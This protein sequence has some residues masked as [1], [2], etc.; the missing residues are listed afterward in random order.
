MRRARTVDEYVAMMKD[1]LYE[2]GDMRAAI[3]YDEE[4]MGASIGYIDDIESCLKGIFKEMKSGDYC[5]NTG[6]LPY[7]RVIRDLDDAAIPFRS[8]LIR[9]NDTHK[10]GLEESPDA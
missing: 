8:L 1:A 2:I 6:D 3:E 10:N 5:W 9:I 4:G 7:I